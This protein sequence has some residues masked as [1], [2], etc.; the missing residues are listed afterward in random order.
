M[1]RIS[2]V[3]SLLGLSLAAVAAVAS[4]QTSPGKPKDATKPAAQDKAPA[5]AEKATVVFLGNATCPGDGKKVDREKF[6]EVDGQRI[7]VCS[8]GCA[9]ALK[10]DTNVTKTAFAKAYPGATPIEAKSCCCG[11]AIDAKKAVDVTFQGRKVRLC[12]ADCAKEFK[13]NPVTAIALLQHPDVKDAKNATDPIDGK[14][15]ETTI[16]GIYK[17]HLIHFASWAN[18]ASFEKDPT[19]TITKLKLAS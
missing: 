13:K 5:A 1:I 18:A 6:V 17:T 3:T 11:A 10:K 9:A 2:F 14:P 16:V 7:Y 15:I 12:C 8:D 19:A 4:A